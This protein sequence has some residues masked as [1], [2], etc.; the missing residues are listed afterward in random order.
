V[1]DQGGVGTLVDV[2]VLEVCNWMPAVPLAPPSLS[3]PTK[4]PH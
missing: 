1:K 4:A 3:S 2:G